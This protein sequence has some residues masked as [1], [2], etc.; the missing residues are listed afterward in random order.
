[1]AVQQLAV[2]FI[3]AQFKGDIELIKSMCTDDFKS[4]VDKNKDTIL[5]RKNGEALFTQI[6]NVAKEGDRYFVFVRLNETGSNGEADYQE[7]FEIIKING[8]YLV[9]FMGNDA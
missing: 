3:I 8:E 9:D 7:N 1:L 6:T 2:N 4:Y 5:W